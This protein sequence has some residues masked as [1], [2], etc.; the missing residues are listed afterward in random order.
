[1]LVSVRFLAAIGDRI[2]FLLVVSDSH[3]GAGFIN[4]VDALVGLETIRYIA[5]CQVGG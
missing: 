4:E 5:F 3:H 1:M 2:H